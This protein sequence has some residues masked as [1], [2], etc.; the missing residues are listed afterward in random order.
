MISKTPI[1]RPLHLRSV[2]QC[3]LLDHYLMCASLCNLCRLLQRQTVCTCPF[4]AVPVCRYRP[5][6]TSVR[7][8]ASV[9][10]LCCR[11]PG[12]VPAL[13]DRALFAAVGQIEWAASAPTGSPRRQWASGDGRSSGPATLIGPTLGPEVMTAWGRDEVLLRLPEERRT[14]RVGMGGFPQDCDTDCAVVIRQRSVCRC[15]KRQLSY[16]HR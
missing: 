3:L 9:P 10:G 15:K 4:P 14:I 2:L 5:V 8:T 6:L 7:R 11:L 1:G 13:R 12:G 16:N